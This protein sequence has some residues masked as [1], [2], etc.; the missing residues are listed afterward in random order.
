M[1]TINI[2]K[3]VFE[4]LVGKK[5]SDEKLKDRI[6]YLGTDLEE[7]NEK[8]IIVEI[9]PNRP[10]MLS[11]QGFARAFSSF[12]NSKTGLRRY[13]ILKSNEKRTIMRQ[14]DE[15]QS[16]VNRIGSKIKNK[17]QIKTH[18]RH[19]IIVPRMIGRRIN[20]YNGKTFVPIDIENEMLGHRLGE[21]S[22]TRTKVKHGSAGVGATR[23]SASRAVK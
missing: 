21:F 15:L 22:V 8:E 23:S 20:V 10:D 6:S 2:N 7:I 5:L 9:F 12:T 18:L 14:S 4:K 3:Q 11:V 16:F 13:N 1:P 19:L 17:K